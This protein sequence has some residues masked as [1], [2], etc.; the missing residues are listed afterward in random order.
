MCLIFE[1][2]FGL[3]R[4]LK[5]I[6]FLSC[7][8]LLSLNAQQ[9]NIG[10]TG[11]PCINNPIDFKSNTPGATNHNWDF[12]GEGMNNTKA[13]PQFAFGTSGLKTIRYTCTLPNGNVCSTTLQLTIKNKPKLK[14]H[15]LTD[16]TQCYEKNS[17]CFVDSSLSGDNTPCIVSIKY[18]FSDGELITRYGTN[19]NPI[20]TPL[21]FCKKYEDPQGG[22]YNLSIEMEDCNG[23]IT[24]IDFP[25]TMRVQF[26]P[27]IFA[28]ASFS[29]K[30]CQS[31]ATGLFTNKS[32][33][34]LPNVKKFKWIF[35]D[36]SEDSTS[37]DSVK[38]TYSTKGKFAAQY[39]P[40]LVIYSSIGCATIYDLNTVTLYDLHPYILADKDSI[41]S[42]ESVNWK[43]GSD[44][45]KDFIPPGAINW[46]TNPG[47]QKGYGITQSIGGL[48][49]KIIRCNIQHPCGPFD[50]YDTLLV[51]G[52]NAA[53]ES[54]YIAETERYQCKIQDSIHVSDLSKFYHNDLNYTDDDSVGVRKAGQMTHIFKKV[55]SDY[56][57][58]NSLIQNRGGTNVVRLWNFN[59][60]FCEQCTTDTKKNQ[61]TWLNCRYSRDSANVHW[62][63]PWDSMYDYTYSDQSFPI[64]I[65]DKV[66]KQCGIRNV[67]ASDSFVIISDTFLYYGNNNIGN[68]SKD[69][70]IFNS[71]TNKTQIP[72]G[73]IG[74]GFIDMPYKTRIYIT[75]NSTVF[76]DKKDGSPPTL[77]NGPQFYTVN[78]NERI[79]IK[80]SNH[81]CYFQY[82][83]VVN[84]DTLPLLYKKPWHK[85]IKRI[86]NLNF[87]AGDSI[88]LNLHRQLFYNTIPKCFIITLN[89]KDT[90]HPF[91]CEQTARASI[92]LMPPSAKKLSIV[93]QYC[94]TYNTKAIDFSLDET[95][96]GCMRSFAKINGD[97]INTPNKWQLI[98]DMN[99][100]DKL[101]ESALSPPPYAYQGYNQVGPAT[102]RF[103]LT[104][105]DTNLSNENVQKINVA[106]I[107]GNGI[108]PNACADTIYYPNFAS[109]PRLSANLSFV[110]RND[111]TAIFNTCAQ[112]SVFTTIPHSIPNTN[113]LASSSSWY[114]IEN[115]TLDT[116]NMVIEYF[117]KVESS[118]RYPNKKVNYTV[119]ERYAQI[120]GLQ[121]LTKRDT[122]FTAIVHTWK[123]KALPGYSYN[124]LKEALAAINLDIDDF[125]DST[126]LDVVWNNIGT[127]GNYASGS[128][129][130]IDTNGMDTPFYFYHIPIS[131]TTLNYKDSSLLPI[132]SIYNKGKFY[133][134]YG[135]KPPKKGVFS[136]FRNVE[137]LSPMY[138]PLNEYVTVVVGFYGEARFADSVI[139]KNNILAAE[140]YFRYY[141]LDRNKVG[142]LDPTDYWQTRKLFAGQKNFEGLTKWDFSKAD[143]DPSKP[144]TIFGGFPYG[145]IG[146]DTLVYLG[147]GA[148]GIYYKTPGL[149]L[150]RVA[151]QDSNNCKDTFSQNLYVTGP[152]AN[153]KT[154]FKTVDCKSIL[155]F[156]DSSYII[157]PC[158]SKGLAPCDFINNWTIRWGDNT[159]SSFN[160]DLPKQIGHDYK[161]IGTYTIW[162]VVRSVSGCVD[163]TSLKIF[164]PGPQPIFAT[165][166]ERT[167][168]VGDSVIFKNNTPFFTSSAQWLWSFG[169]GF[170]SP[171]KDTV[172]IAHPYNKVGKFDVYLNQFD[173]IP[174]TGKYCYAIY[175]DT[176]V[177]QAKIT[178]TVVPY[179][180]VRLIA[181]PMVVCV[182]DV[183]NFKAVLKSLNNYK[184]Y[185]WTYDNK[186]DSNTALNYSKTIAS[187]GVH[188]MH[189]QADTIGLG[190]K[191]CPAVAD[192]TVYADSV[193]ADFTIDVSKEPEFCFTNTSKYAVTYR[194]GFYHDKDITIKKDPF[195]LNTPQAEPDRYLCENFGERGGE[196][197]VCLEATNALGCKDT[198]CKKVFN[199][200][201]IAL[202]P[203]NVFTPSGNDGFSG[204]DKDGNL[205]NNVFSIY[206]KGEAYY[207]LLIY[208]RWGILVF[209]SDDKNNDWNGSVMN[210]GAQCPNGTYYYILDYRYK[211]RKKNEPLLNGV[212][213]LIW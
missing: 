11:V 131:Y 201:E 20:K 137:T 55:G 25:F 93:G 112:D 185:Y 108:D 88:N 70:S 48:G 34:T 120:Q 78:K 163:S 41:C 96:P 64:T 85:E 89:E 184:Q 74:E 174:G 99:G 128:R 170:Y 207:H 87:A 58:V 68:K 132:D 1:F 42:G 47:L 109:F 101:L 79:I 144:G 139:C 125:N 157:D 29:S 44:S 166:T 33:I 81:S 126:I 179:D 84:T 135:F 167:I 67:W 22:N 115:S 127:I 2:V 31:T 75:R 154:S 91:K 72:A 130:C 158:V 28:T 136:I 23:C 3:I 82:A 148:N 37:W 121:Q 69:S 177:N 43:F 133:K 160:K 168:C 164:I 212:V 35:G 100:G 161:A 200:F 45:L 57:S 152:K 6:L 204:A 194:W 114:M 13:N 116:V 105:S 14:L 193:L 165:T 208:D 143:D 119:I 197:W 153:F 18:L 150:V 59:D 63:T 191:A 111:T 122:V 134:A 169:D 76:I 39:N 192:I 80:F 10:Y 30:L 187:V 49:P 61:N 140:P 199:P 138:C 186:K 62:Y 180:S 210:K 24:K 183:I 206:I 181:T 97:Y 86:K 196:Q 151:V 4:P 90:V 141:T 53:I 117:H 56:T 178:I 149:Y 211:S 171:Q 27:A 66:K 103:F 147:Q 16:S 60:D 21:Y 19:A 209:E 46:Y 65:F 95:K 190:H 155:E 129:G 162:L 205:G 102:G 73:L 142:G 123:T 172:L 7:I 38:H 104:Y 213:Q 40:R 36:G 189:W 92:A 83:L 182:G 15:L 202:Q 94:L 98:N 145:K 195:L 51:I 54:P 26:S 32:Q 106:L 17:F 9:C 8:N 203:P 110:G 146:Y 113:S 124:K 118:P 5:L 159:S 175:P 12:N 198:V 188:T 52:P 50:L 77:V 156:F 176:T 107:I 173:S 71:I